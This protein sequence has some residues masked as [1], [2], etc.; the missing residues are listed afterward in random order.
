MSDVSKVPPGGNSNE[1]PLRQLLASVVA[2]LQRLIKAQVE[3]AKTEIAGS[4]AAAAKTGG[5]LTAALLIG[6]T[7][8]LFLLVTIA[9]ALVALGLPVWAGFGIVTLVL[10]LVTAVLILLGRSTAKGIHAPE[11]TI[12]EIEKT[13]AMFSGTSVTELSASDGSQPSDARD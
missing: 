4:A 5:L 10:F 7:G 13:K 6:G 2:D 11:R 12:A 9:Y 3:L 1:V 8:G